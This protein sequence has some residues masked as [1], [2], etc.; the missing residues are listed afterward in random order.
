[1]T[2][3]ASAGNGA[4]FSGWSEPSCSGASCTVMLNAARTVTANFA[5]GVV[6]S[7]AK[8]GN[9]GGLVYSTAV[10]I[11]CGSSCSATVPPGTLVSL[12]A[13]PAPGASFIGWSD[14][15]CTGKVCQVAMSSARTL[16]AT[17]GADATL[18][19]AVL[20][21]GTVTAAGGEISCSAVCSKVFPYGTSL[22]LTATP[23]AGFRFAGWSGAC[24]GTAN[25]CTVTMDAARSV[26]A[27]FEQ[28]PSFQLSVTVGA[29][30][31]VSSS[32]AGIS[33]CS[34]GTCTALFVQGTPV[35]LSASPF[36]VPPSP[37][38]RR[39]QRQ[40]RL[41]RADDH[42]PQRQCQLRG[43]LYQLGGTIQR[44]ERQRLRLP[45]AM[46]CC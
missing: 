6:L 25:P 20:G 40:R 28:A 22:V 33:N 9:G 3:Q 17:F 10:G 41:Q 43:G 45:T 38:G 5:A 39:L 15:A 8:A 29:G 30:G 42:Q 27:N 12:V 18:S 21:S 24:S 1:V 16:T 13:A 11:N 2:L 26:T 36:Q 35:S 14:P 37:A 31:T 23:A 4:T 19:L 34:N 32:P 44:P 7:V 46:C